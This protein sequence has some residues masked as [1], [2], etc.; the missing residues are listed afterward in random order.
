MRSY[1]KEKIDYNNWLY[2]LN[3]KYQGTEFSYENEYD[4]EGYGCDDEGICRCGVI[5]DAKVT[6][7]NLDRIS[8]KILLSHYKYRTSKGID[9]F[10]TIDEYCVERILRF[11][12]IYDCDSFTVNACGG[13]YGEE[14]DSVKINRN[15]KLLSDLNNFFLL[16]ENH[17]KI[18]FVLK[19]EYQKLLPELENLDWQIG[20]INKEDIDFG[21]DKHYKMVKKSNCDFY[22]KHSLPLGIVFAKDGRYRL[23][24]GYHRL[25]ASEKDKAEVIIGRK[26][27]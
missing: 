11:H 8:D 25:C 10:G 23:I 2:E 18:E 1:K 21:S 6:E 4:C 12:K 9:N 27:K 5:V 7:T 16:K 26:S 22:K 17:K 19:M 24:D 14:I 13:Y 15:D 3:F 20:S